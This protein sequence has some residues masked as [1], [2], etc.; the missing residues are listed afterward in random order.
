MDV[1]N[2]VPIRNVELC[3]DPESGLVLAVGS[4]TYNLFKIL[5]YCGRELG[6]G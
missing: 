5:D 6:S 3:S 1:Y 2:S 4:R